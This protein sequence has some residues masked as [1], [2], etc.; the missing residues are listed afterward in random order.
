MARGWKVWTA[1]WIVYI[2][3]GSTYPAIKVIGP[4]DAAASLGRASVRARGVAARG[5][6]LPAADARCASP[7]ARRSRRPASASSLLA[8]GVGVVTVAE[9]RID[10][11]VAAR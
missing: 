7:G 11:S 1:L 6:P 5:D 8:C 4:D 9:T 10:S 3:W 2:V